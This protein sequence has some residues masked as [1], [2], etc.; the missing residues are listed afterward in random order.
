MYYGHHHLAHNPNGY[1]SYS[2]TEIGQIV[3]VFWGSFMLLHITGAWDLQ[4]REPDL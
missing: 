2:I 1:A 4:N 3:H